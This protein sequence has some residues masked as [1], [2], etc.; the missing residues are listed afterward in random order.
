MPVRFERSFTFSSIRSF[1][2]HIIL[3]ITLVFLVS[4]SVVSHQKSGKHTSKLTFDDRQRISFEF[5]RFFVADTLALQPSGT[6]LEP[7]ALAGQNQ[8][9]PTH[10][11]QKKNSISNVLHTE[12]PLPVSQQH[13]NI[14]LEFNY[15]SQGFNAY[16]HPGLDFAAPYGTPIN[17]AA[18]GC[19]KSVTGG[20][21]GGY[22][23]LVIIE[24]GN[25]YTS[26]Y[27]HLQR[28]AAN[29]TPGTCLDAGVLIGYVGMTGR[30]TGPHLHFELRLN[31]QPVKPLF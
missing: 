1:S 26:R 22:G 10:I 19:I 17:S 27:A 24:H 15:I 3:P 18:A 9:G 6:H 11:A 7:I 31:N 25:G 12:L 14:P 5:D 20:Y 30:T 4:I 28:F 23:N 8:G 21:G 29:V 2:T 16:V 13:L